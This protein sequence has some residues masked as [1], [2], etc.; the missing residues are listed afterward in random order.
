MERVFEAPRDMVF[1][2]F[3]RQEHLAEWRGPEG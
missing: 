2:A 1:G 3:S